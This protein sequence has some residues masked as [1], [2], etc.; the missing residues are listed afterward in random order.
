MGVDIALDSEEKPFLQRKIAT[1]G[2]LGDHLFPL[3]VS[4]FLLSNQQ[5]CIEATCFG[6]CIS[7]NPATVSNKLSA[8]GI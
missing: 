1:D 8:F 3:V 2:N 5:S 4:L 7:E 6:I